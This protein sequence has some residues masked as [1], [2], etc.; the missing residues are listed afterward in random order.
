MEEK[1][2][3]FQTP[4]GRRAASGSHPSGSCFGAPAAFAPA[5]FAAAAF[6]GSRF[7]VVSAPPIVDDD[8][9]EAVVAAA[10]G[11]LSDCRERAVATASGWGGGG[12]E[13]EAAVRPRGRIVVG[14]RTEK[15][16]N[17]LVP[18]SQVLDVF[19]DFGR[20]LIAIGGLASHHSVQNDDDFLGHGSI[21]DCLPGSGP[22]FRRC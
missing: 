11:R 22:G 21:H 5:A 2:P 20:R 16:G 1:D 14:F 19:E 15:F 7:G 17:A 13:V 10:S 6:E 4:V 12:G 3:T 9:P 18:G 8:G